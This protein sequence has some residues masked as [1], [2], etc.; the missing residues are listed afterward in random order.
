MQLHVIFVFK[1]LKTIGSIKVAITKLF[2]TL[3][4]V[5]ATRRTCTVLLVR[6]VQGPAVV[7][8]VTS[9]RPGDT[10]ARGTLVL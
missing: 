3:S 8:A 5:A 9:E 4:Q 7:L 2:T 6:V 10:V 1:Q